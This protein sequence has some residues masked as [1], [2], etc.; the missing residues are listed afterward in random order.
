[1]ATIPFIIEL[2]VYWALY[3]VLGIFR[4]FYVSDRGYASVIR[5]SERKNSAKLGSL[6]RAVLDHWVTDEV[7]SS[8][9]YLLLSEETEMRVGI[10][11]TQ[12]D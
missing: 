8:I 5:S 12:K 6:D 11:R 3:I 1:V 4:L 9:Y 2:R 10:K 7:P